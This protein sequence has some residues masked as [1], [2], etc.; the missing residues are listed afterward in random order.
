[1]FDAVVIISTKQIHFQEV[2]LKMKIWVLRQI[3]Y[4]N[5]SQIILYEIMV[6]G[7]LRWMW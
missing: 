7:F 3:L 5:F 6:M 1:M 4:I 2:F